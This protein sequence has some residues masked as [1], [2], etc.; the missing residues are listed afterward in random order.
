MITLYQFSP[1]WGL[2]NASPFCMKL[3]LYLQLAKIPY[4]I[5]AINDPRKAPKGKLPFIRD[6]ETVIADSQWII[7]YLKEKYGDPLDGGLDSQAKATLHCIQRMLDEHFHWVF[8]YARWTDPVGWPVIAPVFFHGVPKWIRSFIAHRMRKYIQ[9]ALHYQGLGRH[10]SAEIYAM[11][12]AD[13][14]AI[15]QILG[16]KPYLLG[17]TPTT[18][19]LCLYAYL[20][21]I[22]EVPL[23]SVLKKEILAL[24]SLC[25]YHARFKNQ[26]LLPS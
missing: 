13:M 14:E 10:T 23:E 12:K 2:L 4:Q 7:A 8:V 25:A 20:A 9:S 17:D 5:K 1:V 15:V 22:L 11:G 21:N 6:G 18:V 26:Q 16:D 24:P 19:D 3:E